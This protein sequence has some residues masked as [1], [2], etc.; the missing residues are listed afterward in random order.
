MQRRKYPQEVHGRMSDIFDTGRPGG[1]V[2]GRFSMI[3]GFGEGG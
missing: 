3:T 2:D 1:I